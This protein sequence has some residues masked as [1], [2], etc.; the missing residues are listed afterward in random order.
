M[1]HKRKKPRNQRAG[2]KDCKPWKINGFGKED[3]EFER[4]SDHK[5][6]LFAKKEAQEHGK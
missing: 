5:R 1:N 6:R 4:F 3:K 2:C